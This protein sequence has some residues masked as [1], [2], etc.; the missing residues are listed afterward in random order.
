MKWAN[1]DLAESPRPD[2]GVRLIELERYVCGELQETRRQE[3][4]KIQRDCLHCQ[5][6]L[7]RMNQD[8]RAFLDAVNVATQSAQILQRS[9]RLASTS[10]LARLPLRP[11]VAALTMA[12]AMVFF[13]PNLQ[14][15]DAPMNRTKGH[16]V[17]LQVYQNVDGQAEL[18][19]SGGRL[20]EGAQIQFRYQAHGFS[21]VMIVS[22]D[23]QNVISSLYPAGSGSSIAI[24]SEGSHVLEGSIILDDALGEERIYAVYSKQALDYHEVEAQLR[25]AIETH[26]ALNFG[27][28]TELVQFSF[29]KVK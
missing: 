14:E 17:G 7:S 16:S 15:S 28:D 1:P 23:G 4:D 19:S 11:W 12:M 29:E 25:Q 3:I 27:R 2:C 13:L 24:Q 9:E 26:Q 18:L 6:A 8:E 10:W 20:S 5:T 22:V 21:Y